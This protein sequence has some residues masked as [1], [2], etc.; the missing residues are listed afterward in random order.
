MCYRCCPLHV[1]C[2]KF[3]PTATTSAPKATS[4]RNRSE[5]W[6][7]MANTSGASM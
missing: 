1:R 2:F 4:A 5:F 3:S 7:F 6:F